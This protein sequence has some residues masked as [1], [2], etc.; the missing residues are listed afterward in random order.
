MLRLTVVSRTEEVVILQVDGNIEAAAVNLLA[1]EIEILLVSTEL[2][3]LELGGVLYV[4]AAGLSLFAG[5]PT[6]RLH[7]QGC[8]AF[9][10]QLL[11]ERCQRRPGRQ[12]H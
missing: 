10:A 5:L 2:V 1:K 12:K 3:V 9:V 7:L 4:D 6:D 11:G 8:S